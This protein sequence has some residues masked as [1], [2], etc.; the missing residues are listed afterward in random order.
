[1]ASVGAPVTTIGAKDYA[2]VVPGPIPAGLTNLHL[3]NRGKE[4]HHLL[5]YR[6]EQGKSVADVVEALKAAQ[7]GAA[8]PDWAVPSGGPGGVMPGAESNATLELE[9]GSYAAVCFVPDSAGVPH[10]MR[11]MAQ[12]VE[13]TPAETAT[14]VK[15][16]RAD[17]TLELVDYDFRFSEPL[18]P[19]TWNVRVKNEGPQLHE[20]HFWR[21]APGK[22]LGDLTGWLAGSEQGPPPADVVGGVSTIEAGREALVNLSLEP[23]EYALIC[24]E[25]DKKDGKPHFQHGM[26]KQIT[27]G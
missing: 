11:G 22:S 16:P 12:A 4:I 17:V 14:R 6:L 23:A 13:V 24:F 26:A 25:P 10:V 5:L 27:V 1:M 21:L 15:E 20:V 19:G 7:T 8:F 9:P 2:F 18:A 3:A